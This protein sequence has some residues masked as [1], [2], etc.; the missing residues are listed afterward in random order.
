M[1]QITE[2]TLNDEKLYLLYNHAPC[3]KEIE[4][5]RVNGGFLMRV[6][7]NSTTKDLN[8]NFSTYESICEYEN[9]GSHNKF[10]EVLMG[11]PSTLLYE[12]TDQEANLVLAQIV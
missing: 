2:K 11:H 5:F 4:I 12:L 7:S 8:N 1:I 3:Y 10:F 9:T 6:L